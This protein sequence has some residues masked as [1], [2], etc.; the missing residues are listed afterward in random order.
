MVLGRTPLPPPP[1]FSVVFREMARIVE[2]LKAKEN[3]APTTKTLEFDS[4]I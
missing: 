4:E 2:A 1:R 3:D